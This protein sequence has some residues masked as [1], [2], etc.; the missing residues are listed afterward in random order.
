MRAL[1]V[2]N[3]TAGIRAH[4]RDTTADALKLADYEVDNILA[5]EGDV[6]R[7]LKTE[8]DL[9]VAAGGD[10]TAVYVFMHLAD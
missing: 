7:A 3:P 8:C 5:K 6:K 10:E 2:H 9:V 4:N 1:L